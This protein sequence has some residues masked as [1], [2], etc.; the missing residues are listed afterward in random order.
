MLRVRTTAQHEINSI[1]SMEKFILGFRPGVR[2]MAECMDENNGN[3]TNGEGNIRKRKDGRW[4]GRY[5]AGYDPETG[6]RIIW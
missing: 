4:E 1:T 5:N 6:K 3:L 2:L